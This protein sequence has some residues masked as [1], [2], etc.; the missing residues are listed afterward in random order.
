MIIVK[1]I[2]AIL[3]LPIM[4]SYPNLIK[5]RY[6]QHFIDIAWNQKNMNIARN[7]TKISWIVCYPLESFIDVAT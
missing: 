3:S 5:S 4:V 7:T 1:K 6:Y 2:Y